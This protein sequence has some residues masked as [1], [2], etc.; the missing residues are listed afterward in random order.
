MAHR[1]PVLVILASTLIPACGTHVSSGRGFNPR[2]GEDHAAEHI[3]EPEFTPQQNEKVVTRQEPEP[4]IA[5][6]KAVQRGELEKVRT[7]IAKDASLA[8]S[9]DRHGISPLRTAVE[10]H[11]RKIAEVLIAA[12]AELDIE[13]AAEFGDKARVAALLKKEPWLAKAPRKALHAAARRGDVEIG[14]SLLDN[15]AD[16]NLDY[17][18]SNVAGSFTPLSAAVQSRHFAFA[19][20]LC[21]H[22]ASTNAAGGKNHDSLCHL[23]VGFRSPRWTRLFLESGAN[24]NAVDE[25]NLTLAH[26]AADRGDVEKL[27]ILLDYKADINRLTPEGSSPLFFAAVLDHPEACKFLL[28]HGARLDIYSACAL[29]VTESVAGMLSADESHARRADGRLGRPPLFW[30]CHNGNLEL[31]QL[32][33]DNG[34]EVNVSA[35]YFSEAIN[36]V[37][38]PQVT[39]R[40][41]GE[42]PLQVAAAAGHLNVVRRLIDAGA[43]VDGLGRGRRTPLHVASEHHHSAVA[44]FLLER[45]AVVNAQDERLRT[46]LHYAVGDRA[47]V[48]TLLTARPDLDAKSTN[49]QTPMLAATLEGYTDV[50][51]LLL[52]N[53]AKLDL[54]SASV[55]GKVDAVKKLLTAEPGLRD[56]PTEGYEKKTPLVLACEAGQVEVVKE[57]LRLGAGKRAGKESFWSPMRMAVMNGRIEVLRVLIEKGFPVTPSVKNDWGPL[58]DASAAAQPESLRFLLE[59]GADPRARIDFSG[60]LLHI[61]GQYTDSAYSVEAKDRGRR[62]VEV[63]RLLVEAGVA[64]GECNDHGETPLHWAAERGQPELAAFLI[65]KGVPVNPVDDMGRTPLWIALNDAELFRPRDSRGVAEVLRK[66]GGV[67]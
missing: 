33:L 67:E 32:L 53:G 60:S 55:L 18:F 19:K 31:V 3:S 8:T 5:F 61:I 2:I 51:E 28:D 64:V 11:Q 16:P 66:H 41:S 27:K 65:S 49:G 15:R 14:K 26:V 62:E 59:K 48:E 57:L 6:E 37:E 29:G 42:T 4:A 30:A 23:V 58:G 20:L 47:T 38:G 56:T 10:C 9:K 12:G 34:A 35:P 39:D 45:G 1:F 43:R 22:G 40:K 21:E 25:W 24:P 44:K 36:V 17:G 52:K 50:A 13:E 46:P 7:L 54:H 63:A